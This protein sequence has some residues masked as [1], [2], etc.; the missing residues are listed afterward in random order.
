MRAP[1]R[2][3]AYARAHTSPTSIPHRLLDRLIRGRAWIG[4][5]AFALI[6]IV[7]MQLWIVK[8]GYGIGRAVE[9]EG[10]L[11]RENSALGIE[12]AELSSGERVERLA[13]AKGMV[14]AAPGALRFDA[15]RPG[16]DARLAAAALAHGTQAGAVGA[17]QGTQSS[18]TGSGGTTGQG[19]G[20]STGAAEETAGAASTATNAAGETPASTQEAAA[21]SSEPSASPGESTAP[22]SSESTTPSGEAS[23]SSG[24]AAP[25]GEAATAAGA[26]SAP[27]GGS[28][29]AAA[30]QSE[31][32][33]GG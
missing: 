18:T 7:A 21:S 33:P 17:G 27:A 22:S 26:A 19:G 23:A 6:G 25:S 10:L 1:A 15:V 31:A 32:S 4:I 11:R 29:P 12:N 13:A 16:L 24:E 3:R 20:E 28:T 5:V 8:L 9:H 2:P 14:E 30:G